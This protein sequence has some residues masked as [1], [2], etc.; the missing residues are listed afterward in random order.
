MPP[1]TNPSIA[2]DTA[3]QAAGV[4]PWLSDMQGSS[5]CGQRGAKRSGHRILF[6]ALVGRV[7]PLVDGAP[8]IEVLHLGGV[9]VRRPARGGVVSAA[10]LRPGTGPAYGDG[11]G[12]EREHGRHDGAPPPGGRVR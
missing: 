12:R 4:L 1:T 10:H 2:T 11:R 3:A 5:A 7:A 6:V 9:A 8:Q